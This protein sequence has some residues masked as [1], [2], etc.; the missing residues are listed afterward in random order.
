MYLFATPERDLGLQDLL[1]LRTMSR[2]ST[3]ETMHVQMCSA[4]AGHYRQHVR[5]I[6]TTKLFVHTPPQAPH[7]KAHVKVKVLDGVGADVR[8]HYNFGPDRQGKIIGKGQFGTVRQA[9]SIKTGEQVAVKSIAKRKLLTDEEVE[10]V[11]REVAIL[12]HLVGHPALAQIHGVYEDKHYVHIV[13]Q[14]G[15]CL[16]GVSRI[17]GTCNSISGA[18]LGLSAKARSLLGIF[19]APA[20]LAS[21]LSA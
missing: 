6:K 10:D 2:L 20:L 9:T 4:L 13:M 12:H 5:F 16:E 8:E 14:V 15:A 18:L 19:A 17:R 3:S 7:D 21:D 1:K 11:R